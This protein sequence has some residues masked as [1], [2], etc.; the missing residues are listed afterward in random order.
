MGEV[1]LF[2]RRICAARCEGKSEEGEAKFTDTVNKN[3]I[4]G[5]DIFNITSLRRPK[6]KTFRCN[7]EMDSHQELIIAQELRPEQRP[8]TSNCLLAD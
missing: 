3:T 8:C 5:I 1:Y 4:N 6:P 7:E 2:R